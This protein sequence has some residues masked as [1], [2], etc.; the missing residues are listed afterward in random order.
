MS[1]LLRD[2]NTDSQKN[3]CRPKSCHIALKN[4]KSNSGNPQFFKNIRHT[5]QAISVFHAALFPPVPLYPISP[6][7][8]TGRLN[9]L[10]FEKKQLFTPPSPTGR[11]LRSGL[12]ASAPHA[13]HPCRR[14]S[15]PRGVSPVGKGRINKNSSF[16]NLIFNN[17]SSFCFT[18]KAAWLA[19]FWK[20]FWR[21]K[22]TRAVQ[23]SRL[24][25]GI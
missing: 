13:V 10:F 20:I 5:F 6:P 23:G 22:F 25:S 24:S 17:F 15:A 12:R 8:P 19:A 2:E 21:I 4:A 3:D 14:A 11:G 9:V 16:V 1:L 18:K 7:P